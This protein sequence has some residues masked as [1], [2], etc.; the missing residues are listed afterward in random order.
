MDPDIKLKIQKLTE[1]L[2]QHN[3]NYYVLDAPTISDFDF[4][5]KLE[6]LCQLEKQYPEFAD[7]NSPTQRIGGEIITKF[8][9]V[10]HKKRMYSLNNTYSKTELKE[11]VERIHKLTDKPIDFVCE[12]KYDGVAISITY[13]NGKLHRAITRG[14]G[15]K[16][17]D[18]TNNVRN[19]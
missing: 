18:I 14:D 6:S 13:K 11:Y 8:E 7:K 19:H 3:Y 4:D 17:D 2:H 5:K 16:G 1:E 15:I 12:L 10:K 9:T